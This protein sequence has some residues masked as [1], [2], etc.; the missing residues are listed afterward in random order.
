VNGTENVLVFP[1]TVA[2]AI[3][4]V[5]IVASTDDKPSACDVEYESWA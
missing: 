1:D 3:E 5:D 2:V 4:F